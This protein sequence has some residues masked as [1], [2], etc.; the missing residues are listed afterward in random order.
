MIYIP[1]NNY[2]N[3]ASTNTPTIYS[4]DLKIWLVNGEHLN[5]AYTGTGTD[6]LWKVKVYDEHFLFL[7]PS[8][9]NAATSCS[10]TSC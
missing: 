1:N 3:T 6:I 7:R 5:Q 10:P 4:G 2:G 9:T 8:T